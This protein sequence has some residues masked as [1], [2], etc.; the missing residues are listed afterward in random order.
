MA[1][2]AADASCAAGPPQ[3]A[4]TAQA[5]APSSA[6]SAR[7]R[8]G[9]TVVKASASRE[10]ILAA[11]QVYGPTA[12]VRHYT[13]GGKLVRHRRKNRSACAAPEMVSLFLA[14]SA[15]VD[16]HIGAQPVRA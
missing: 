8:P 10:E 9:W 4:Q 2:R 16:K 13:S 6:A 14:R 11:R 1:A 12:R 7:R 5:S 15:A 3:E